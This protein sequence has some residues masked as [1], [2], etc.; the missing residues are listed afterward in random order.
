MKTKTDSQSKPQEA[1]TLQI[2]LLYVV[3]D[4]ENILH[5]DHEK[6]CTYYK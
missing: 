2:T 3:Y 5:K 1:T 6:W 4:H